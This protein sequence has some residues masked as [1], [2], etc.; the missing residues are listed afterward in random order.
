MQTNEK[1][2]KQTSMTMW[3]HLILRWTKQGLQCSSVCGQCNGQA[4]LNTSSYPKNLN[5]ESEIESEVL[6]D[7][8]PNEANN[9]DVDNDL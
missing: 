2:Q 5:E 7:L 6:K 3:N 4:C 8:E 9:E 1:I